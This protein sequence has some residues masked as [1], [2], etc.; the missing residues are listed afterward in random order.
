M[1]SIDDRR[2]GAHCPVGVQDDWIHHRV[3]DDGHK[4]PQLWVIV[5]I[6][7]QNTYLKTVSKAYILCMDIRSNFGCAIASAVC[8][9]G[10]SS[11]LAA[12]GGMMQ[13]GQEGWPL[14]QPDTVPEQPHPVPLAAS[15]SD[16]QAYQT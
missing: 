7:L 1:G 4:L 8:L 15:G 5:Q 10:S 16:V 3:M 12:S 11:C 2:H 9:T 6:I 13:F 14:L